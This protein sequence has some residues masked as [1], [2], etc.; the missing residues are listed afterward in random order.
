MTKDGGVVGV[1]TEIT[2]RVSAEQAARDQRA[3]LQKV[4]DAIPAIVDV[5][6]RFGRYVLANKYLADIYQLPSKDMLGRL[7]G[8]LSATLEALPRDI[9]HEELDGA[10]SDAGE[11]FELDADQDNW[12]TTRVP[13]PNDRGDA[14]YLLTVS[15]DISDRNRIERELRDSETR[16][17]GLVESAPDAILINCDGKIA[18]ANAY[19]LRLFGATSVADLIGTTTLDRV[20]P[21]HRGVAADRIADVLS[22]DVEISTAM[23]QRLLR[24]DGTIV[25]VESRG[26]R[27]MWEGRSAVQIVL[28]D[29]TERKKTEQDL[30]ESERRY[31]TLVEQ[32]PDAIIINQSAHIV[33]A[34]QAA[35][36][37]FGVENVASLLGLPAED[38]VHPDLRQL[39]HERISHVLKLG[40]VLPLAEVTL[41]RYDGTQ[42]DVETTGTS[43]SWAGQR[44]VQLVMRDVSERKRTEAALHLTQFS[45]DHAADAVFWLR[46]SGDIAYVNDSACRLLGYGHAELMDLTIDRIDPEMPL[47]AWDQFVERTK[48]AEFHLVHERRLRTKLGHLVPVEISQNFLEFGD[49]AYVFA[50]ARDISTRRAAEERAR[51]HVTD[52][53]HVLRT[54]TVGD[55]AAALAEQLKRPLDSIATAAEESLERIRRGSAAPEELTD[56]LERASDDVAYASDVV[57]DIGSF[58]RR[59]APS[60]RLADANELVRNTL[61]LA[62][63]ELDAADVASRLDLTTS[64]PRAPIDEVEIEQVILN[65][66][67]N[68]IEAMA[69]MRPDERLLTIRTGLASEHEIEV[70]ITDSGPGLP[71]EALAKMFDPFFSTKPDHLG[72]GLTIARSL[73]EAHHGRLLAT[74]NPAGGATFRIALPIELR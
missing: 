27:I 58:V 53:A 49:Q 48:Q 68:G 8:E 25:T 34:N 16:Y 47:V 44:A 5:K 55:M 24:L 28:R 73:V 63:S 60:R 23:E 67:R 2:D 33:F 32:S 69:G 41:L 13:L 62:N 4:V 31:R 12:L 74:Q 59:S 70:A 50:F 3:F 26:G 21:N 7:S 15:F 61:A 40:G 36:R 17:R 51:R 19:A 43:I 20:H 57:N 71:F 64:L 45:V 35:L 66:V 38:L 72:M 29:V 1:H 22:G 42:L 10:R 11:N 54:T 18:F 9:E 52:L 65:I 30:R 6:D 56:L 37:L 46:P 14:D 39:A